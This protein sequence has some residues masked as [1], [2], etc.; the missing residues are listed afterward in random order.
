MNILNDILLA[1]QSRASVFMWV[2]LLLLFVLIYYVPVL[3]ILRKDKKGIIY[4]LLISLI[5][6][7]LS[8]IAVI[9]LIADFNGIKAHFSKDV[10]AN[11]IVL[12]KSTIHGTLLFGVLISVLY[13]GIVLIG[14]FYYRKNNYEK[15]ILSDQA[16]N[17]IQFETASKSKRVLNCLIDLI[18]VMALSIIISAILSTFGINLKLRIISSILFLMYY[19]LF[20]YFI[21][22][23]IGKM[24]TKTK[25]ISIY[26]NKITIKMIFLREFIRW[27]PFE[28]FSFINKKTIGWHDKAS[29]IIVIN[30]NIST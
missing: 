12:F 25:I 14:Y 27:V 22:K 6:L 20:E 10:M 24:I 3:M 23:T 29:E 9:R 2:N 19:G 11:G 4:S 30:S 26:N 8:I 21:G 7:F 17:N 13:V 18:L 15:K 16:W 5:P 1:F 28:Q